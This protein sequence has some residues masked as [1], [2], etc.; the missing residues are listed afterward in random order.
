MWRDTGEGN[1]PGA[2]TET[3]DCP[4]LVLG[5]EAD[6]LV[7]PEVTIKLAGRIPGA[8]FGILPF[9]DHVV[10]QTHPDQVEPYIIEFIET[11]TGVG[12]RSPIGSTKTSEGST[13]G[14]SSKAT[15]P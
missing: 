11:C 8:R 14:M 12:G 5:G 9:G 6:H 2:L 10:F 7:P 4:A 13:N 1:Y 15:D 3:I